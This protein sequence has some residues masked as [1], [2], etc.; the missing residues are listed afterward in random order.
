MQLQ[1]LCRCLLH[2]DNEHQLLKISVTNIAYKMKHIKECQKKSILS[3]TKRQKVHVNCSI[4]GL[5][6]KCKLSMAMI[7]FC[8]C[9]LIEDKTFFFN[10]ILAIHKCVMHN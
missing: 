10:V 8:L 3:D 2:L 1:I 4:Y 6:A 9:M 7:K 5:L